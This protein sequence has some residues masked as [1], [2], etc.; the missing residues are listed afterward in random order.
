M[1]MDILLPL[2]SWYFSSRCHSSH[3]IGGLV[4]SPLYGSKSGDPDE[5]LV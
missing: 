3:D 2:I 1:G 5:G 4:W